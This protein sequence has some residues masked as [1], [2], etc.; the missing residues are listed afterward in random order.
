MNNVIVLLRRTATSNLFHDVLI[1]AIANEAFERAML[2]SGFFQEKPNFSASLALVP[3]YAPNFRRTHLQLTTVGIYNN[4]WRP[5]F[6]TFVWSL[7]IACPTYLTV[8]KRRTS[9]WH[10][11]VFIA[12]EDGVPAFGIIGSSN[13]TR[14]A[15]G[16]SKPFNFEADVVMWDPA[17]C[18]SSEF[19]ARAFAERRPGHEFMV[20]SYSDSRSNGELFVSDRLGNLAAQI[21]D[22]SRP[23]E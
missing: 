11:K 15:F 22:E 18:G 16:K 6:D 17:C 5:Q 2:C 19:G 12:W 10:A 9:R 21:M 23:T 8:Q 20:A 4:L 13:M 7:Q 3:Q 1:Q 14:P